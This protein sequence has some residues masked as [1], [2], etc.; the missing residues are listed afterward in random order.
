M[1]YSNTLF[2]FINLPPATLYKEPWKVDI[3]GFMLVVWIWLYNRGLKT[4][5]CNVSSK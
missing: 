2:Y 4:E 1:L 3:L 5:E